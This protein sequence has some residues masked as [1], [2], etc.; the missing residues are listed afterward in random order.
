MWVI[1]MVNLF[2]KEF[3]SNWNKE[4]KLQEKTKLPYLKFIMII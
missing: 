2:E 4:I 1:D 3:E